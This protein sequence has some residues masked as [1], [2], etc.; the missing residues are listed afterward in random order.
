MIS[1]RERAR[2]AAALADG[3]HSAHLSGGDVTPAFLADAQDYVDGLISVGEL[4]RR[5]KRR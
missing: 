2:R 1:E 3:R 5:T 4:L